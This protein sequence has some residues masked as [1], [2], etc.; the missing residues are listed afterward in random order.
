[1]HVPALL[2]AIPLLAGSAGA[3]FSAAHLPP[4]FT[5][6]TASGALLAW[7]AGVATASQ[8]D[9]I[10]ATV[11]VVFGALLSGTSLGTTAATDAYA[12]PILQWFNTATVAEP[13]S[14]Q[15]VLREDAM[16]GEFG[17]SLTVDVESIATLHESHARQTTGLHSRMGGVRLAVGGGLIDGRVSEWRAGRTVRVPAL[18]RRPSTYLNPGTSDER[19]SLARRGIALVGSIKSATLVEVVSRGTRLTEAAAS[20]RAWVRRRIAR[21]IAPRST[22]SAGIT[23]AV[24]IGDRSGLS[25]E[26]ERRLQAAGTYHVIAISGGNVAILSIL[27]MFVCRLVLIPSRIA[28]VLTAG[29]LCF[30][31]SIAV[32]GASVSRAVIVAAVMLAARALDQR[33]SSLNAVGV[34]AIVAAAVS[35]VVVFDAGFLLSFG[36]TTGILLGAPHLVANIGRQR[37]RVVTATWLLGAATICAELALA[38]IGAAFFS[39]VSFAGLLLNFVAIPLMTCIQI[40]GLLVAACAGWCDPVTRLAALVADVAATSLLQSARLVDVAPWLSLDVRPPAWWVIVSYYIAITLTL[41]RRTRRPAAVVLT[42]V[43]G[44]MVVGPDMATHDAWPRGSAPLRVVVFDVGQGDATVVSLPDSRALLVDAGGLATLSPTADRV[45][46][47]AFDIGER[48]VTP[49]LRALGVRRLDSLVL[50]HGDPDHLLGAKGVLRHVQA[51]SIWEG[52]PVPPHSGLQTLAA[53]ARQRAM[54]WRTVQAGDRERF[55]DVEVR[56]LHP[57]PPDWERQRVRNE[58]SVVLELRIGQVSIVLPGDI[59][60]EGERAILPRLERGRLVI[61]K[62]PHHGSATSSTPPLLD[63]LRPAAVIF[64]CGR[65]N[66]FGHPHPAVVDRYRA[67]GSAIFSTASDGAVMVDSDGTTVEVR[68]RT[69]KQT[70]FGQQ[71]TR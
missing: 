71:P 47:V 44:L 45:E 4:H 18:L 48:I 7:L 27:A 20:I 61:L 60:H 12:P 51:A 14:V 42:A 29:G 35:P 66:R 11:A 8:D 41:H 17:L 37:A 46:Q 53:L 10:E 26:D 57:P 28:A 40:A 63:T 36:A 9:R 33:G 2:V 68:G 62:A 3:V 69:G 64:S 67:I 65:D 13:V 21:Y 34:A 1:M 22:A 49:A 31:G 24:L 70:R 19:P 52:V 43:A 54:T 16:A 32:S 38:P 58:D 55:G 39:R 59:G 6:L 56:V 50:T 23:T 30:Y 25:V 5:F 15:G